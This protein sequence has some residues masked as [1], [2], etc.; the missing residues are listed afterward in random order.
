MSIGVA[1]EKN[2]FL[3]VLQVLHWESDAF[4]LVDCRDGSAH[5]LMPLAHL[6][7]N[8]HTSRNRTISALTACQLS[9]VQPAAEI[10][11]SYRDLINSVISSYVF[12]IFLSK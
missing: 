6:I 2:I 3:S 7:C 1:E 11:C 4:I 12:S 8:M 5:R 9:F 10:K